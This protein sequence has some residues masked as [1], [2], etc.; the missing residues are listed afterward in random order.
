[1][2]LT[3]GKR[4]LSVIM[5][6]AIVISLSTSGAFATSTDDIGSVSDEVHE[7]SFESI[8]Y[9]TIEELPDGGKIYVYEIDGVTHRFPL[10]PKDFDA[11]K[12]TDEQLKTYGIPPRPDSNNEEDYRSWVET[13]EGVDFVP[14][15]KLE[16]KRDSEQKNLSNNA[17]DRSNLYPFINFGVKNGKSVNLSGYA[18][19]LGSNDSRFYTQVQ[20]DYVEPEIRKHNYGG[21]ANSTWVGFGDLNGQRFVRAGTA[22]EPFMPETH[23]AWFECISPSQTNDSFQKIKSVAVSPGDKIHIYL[24]FSAANDLFNWYVVNVT[25]GQ[26]KSGTATYDADIYFDGSSVEWIVDRRWLVT[27]NHNDGNYGE[28]G[29]YGSIPFTNCKAMLNTS[30]SWTNLANLSGVYPITMT[31]NGGSSGNTLSYPGSINGD[32]FTCYWRGYN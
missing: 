16:V 17:I 23:Y 30:T 7:D 6:S 11:L 27:D 20:V 26:A 15:T 3:I 19:S 12:A 25:K 32:R 5:A 28:L 24:A 14:T 1:M 10:P 13:V 21:Q 4:L 31:S 2:R 18:S 22:I 9:D 29:N 8:A